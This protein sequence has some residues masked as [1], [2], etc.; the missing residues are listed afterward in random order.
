MREIL[1]HNKSISILTTAIFIAASFMISLLIFTDYI[2][3]SS[4]RI[5]HYIFLTF[6]IAYLIYTFCKSIIMTPKFS[7][8]HN[9]KE[10]VDKD[11]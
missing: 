7:Q 8:I 2:N 5:I 6:L 9:L 10:Y 11:E 1:H 3:Q 4:I